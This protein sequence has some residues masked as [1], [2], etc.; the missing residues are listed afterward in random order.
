MNINMNINI[1]T[2]FG[3]GNAYLQDIY[4][5]EAKTPT[6]SNSTQ[7]T[8]IGN[9][10]GGTNYDNKY[11]TSSSNYANKDITFDTKNTNLYVGTIDNYMNK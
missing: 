10:L 8:S 11:T 6:F 2:K 5:V 4:S 7:L 9:K 1:G 3:S